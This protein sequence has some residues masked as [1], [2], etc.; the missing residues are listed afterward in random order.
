MSIKGGTIRYNQQK[1]RAVISNFLKEYPYDAPLML[2]DIMDYIVTLPTYL[3]KDV[4]PTKQNIVGP[5]K[6]SRYADR[7]LFNR[8]LHLVIE[9][10]NDEMKPSIII[11]GNWKLY[12]E[13]KTYRQVFV[14]LKSDNSKSSC[15]DCGISITVKV[16]L[17][18]KNGLQKYMNRSF[19]CSRCYEIYCGGKLPQ[20]N[21]FFKRDKEV[22]DEHEDEEED[23]NWLDDLMIM[24]DDENEK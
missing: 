21:F 3:L 6:K 10:F 9:E 5:T 13:S 18:K 15:F 8:L 4:K 1:C 11:K 17:R 22:V 20:D 24:E 12:S 23:E 7:I 16:D 2:N 14:K 19:T